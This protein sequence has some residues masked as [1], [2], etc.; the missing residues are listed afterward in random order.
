MQ[1]ADQV[2]VPALISGVGLSLI[3]AAAFARPRGFGAVPLKEHNWTAQTLTACY[4]KSSRLKL[5]MF[6]NIT[7]NIM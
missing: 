6:K 4:S 5:H 1:S 7:C 2:Q 3:N